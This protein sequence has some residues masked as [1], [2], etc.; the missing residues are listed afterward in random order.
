MI[1]QTKAD[2]SSSE[3]DPRG[4]LVPRDPQSSRTPSRSAACS[5]DTAA[6]TRT[7]TSARSPASSWSPSTCLDYRW[8]GK[9]EVSFREGKP[10]STESLRRE[11]K[12]REE[13]RRRR[14]GNLHLTWTTNVYIVPEVKQLPTSVPFKLTWEKIIFELICILLSGFTTSSQTPETFLEICSVQSDFSV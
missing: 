11:E 1:V 2:K 10:E 3:P 9:T 13:K 5:P 14:G 4:L 12:R 7:Q 8:T 6:P